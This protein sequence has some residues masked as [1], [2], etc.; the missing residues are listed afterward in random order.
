M[1]EK[2]KK[3]QNSKSSQSD[4]IHKTIPLVCLGFLEEFKS[5]LTLSRTSKAIQY[6]DVLKFAP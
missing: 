6:E 5:K 3:I 4:V 2:L 1:S